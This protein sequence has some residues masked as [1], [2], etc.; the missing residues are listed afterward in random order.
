M[1]AHATRAGGHAVLS[2][3]ESRGVMCA[4]RNIFS[5]PR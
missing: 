1:L 5:G 4:T 2:L 3:R